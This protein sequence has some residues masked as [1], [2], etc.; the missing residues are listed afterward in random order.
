MAD[1]AYLDGQPIQASEK[2]LFGRPANLSTQYYSAKIVGNYSQHSSK[3]KITWDSCPNEILEI[4]RSQIFVSRKRKR[5]AQNYYN[6]DE[7]EVSRIIFIV[8]FV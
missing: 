1:E 4:S 5:K 6:E 8:D 7:E 2:P 3:I